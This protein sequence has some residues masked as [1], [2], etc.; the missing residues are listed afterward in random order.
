MSSL[1][2]LIIQVGAKKPL[3]DYLL[4]FLPPPSFPSLRKNIW[5]VL[6]VLNYHRWIRAA[7]YTLHLWFQTVKMTVSPTTSLGG[8]AQTPL[9][10]QSPSLLEISHCKSA[11]VPTNLQTP[12]LQI[13]Y[14]TT[15]TPILITPNR[16]RRLLRY[17][18]LQVHCGGIGHI[19][20]WD[21]QNSSF[22]V[23]PST[24]I[25]RMKFW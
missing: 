2:L 16:H 12:R 25:V 5:L 8:S 17:N 22:V 24:K 18:L 7:R 20:N 3:F 21:L 23:I 10:L 4:L 1:R 13:T 6:R 14:Y 11:Q 9:H 15:P 19:I